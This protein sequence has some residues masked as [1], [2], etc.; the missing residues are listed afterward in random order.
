MFRSQVDTPKK[1]PLSLFS[2]LF[3]PWCLCGY[4]PWEKSKKPD[5]EL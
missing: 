5:K 3:V 2:F 4:P 1:A